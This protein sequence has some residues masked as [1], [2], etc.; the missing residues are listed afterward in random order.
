MVGAS[1]PE[2]IL[3][4]LESREELL[5][6]IENPEK[7]QP[8]IADN[9]LEITDGKEKLSGMSRFNLDID[10]KKEEVH[11]ILAHRLSGSFQ[12]PKIESNHSLTDMP[13]SV[14]KSKMKTSNLD[15]YRELPE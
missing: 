3:E 10:S 1:M 8:R 13:K 5:G 9:E 7:S 4:N 6:K 12:M 2:E 14:E 11:P 15:P